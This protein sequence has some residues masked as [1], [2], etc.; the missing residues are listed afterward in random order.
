VTLVLSPRLRCWERGALHALRRIRRIL[1]RTPRKF[2]RIPTSLFKGAQTQGE[3]NAHRAEVRQAPMRAMIRGAA[4]PNGTVSKCR[5]DGGKRSDPISASATTLHQRQHCS[6]VG[7]VLAGGRRNRS[8]RIA[9]QRLLVSAV[10]RRTQ[11]VDRPTSLVAIVAIGEASHANSP[12]YSIS[13][14][15]AQRPIAVTGGRGMCR[16]NP[17]PPIALRRPR[18]PCGARPGYPSGRSGRGVLRGAGAARKPR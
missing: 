18:A 1:T 5:G 7:G 11:P 2:A 15:C 3:V 8:P 17:L 14:L 10:C 6:Q 12:P 13:R 9:A 4:A 16:R